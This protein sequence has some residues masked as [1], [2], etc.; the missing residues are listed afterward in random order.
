M[1]SSA[2]RKR[3]LEGELPEDTTNVAGFGRPAKKRR[4]I[5][6]KNEGKNATE[7]KDEMCIYAVYS[8]TTFL[9]VDKREPDPWFSN[10][11]CN[12]KSHS[13]FSSAK[14]ANKCAKDIFKRNEPNV[15]EISSCN[16]DGDRSGDKSKK[17]KDK[18]QNVLFDK[19]HKPVHSDNDNGDEN[20][21][22]VQFHCWVE[23]RRVLHKY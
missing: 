13:I 7:E 22:Y 15:S 2:N 11:S 23:K 8:E 9:D 12:T 6:T 17:K 19:K 18:K 16:E 21:A 5:N 4:K 3:K 1:S 14:E 20:Q 10:N